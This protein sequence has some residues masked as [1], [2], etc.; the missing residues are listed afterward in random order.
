MAYDLEF[1]KPLAELE[2]KIISLQRKGDRLKP[3]EHKQLQEAERELRR[4]S[5]EIYKNLSSWETVQVARHKDRPYSLDYIN[6]MCEDFFELHGD[7]SFSD[8]HA[9]VA[10]PAKLG[11]EPVMLVCPQTGPDMQEKHF[12]NLGLPHPA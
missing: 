5:E 6:L 1:E 11:D 3:D 7:R 9:I 12:P 8:D 2:K 4:R 10:G